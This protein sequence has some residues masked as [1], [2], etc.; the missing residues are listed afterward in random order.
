MK[1]ADIFSKLRELSIKYANKGL[2]IDFEFNRF[3][4]I[5]RGWLDLSLVDYDVYKYN[6]SYSYEMIKSL[7][8]EIDIEKLVDEFKEEVFR[9]YKLDKRKADSV[10]GLPGWLPKYE[11]EWVAD[12]K[13]V[14][15]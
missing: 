3:A 10:F 8:D 9:Q 7:S 15:E 13:E 6:R 12:N 2:T 14:E 1:N 11:G 4:M 5:L